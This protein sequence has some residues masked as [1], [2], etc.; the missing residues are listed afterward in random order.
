MLLQ[1]YVLANQK[2]DEQ[3]WKTGKENFGLRL[4]FEVMEG[5]TLS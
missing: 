5:Y 1:G 2:K 3:K 4:D